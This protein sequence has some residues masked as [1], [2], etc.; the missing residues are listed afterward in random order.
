[1]NKALLIII[2]LGFMCIFSMDYLVNSLNINESNNSNNE[3]KI[4][5]RLDWNNNEIV[6]GNE[7]N[8]KIRVFNLK[9]KNYD[10]KLY[11]YEDDKNDPISQS[12]DQD[13]KWISS[14]RYVKDFFIG[15]GN[16]SDS[17][18]LR[19]NQ[20]Y[21]LFAGSATIIARIRESGTSSYIEEQEDI[22]I[23]KNKSLEQQTGNDYLE[24]DNNANAVYEESSISKEVIRIGANKETESIKTQNN[25]VYESKNE[26][27][28]RYSIYGFII[29][30][31]IFLILLALRWI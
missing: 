10:V 18:K 20:K 11:I 26:L 5:L 22:F 15:P 21:Y 16:E 28:K 25:I 23:F 6:N 31:I 2:I 14:D 8:I 19:I 30:I 9:D 12:R 17:M 29:L 3:T 1:M 7:F 24:Q 13:F 4:F 27:I